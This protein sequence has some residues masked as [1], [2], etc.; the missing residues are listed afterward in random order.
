MNTF[1]RCG[2][3]FTGNEDEPRSG[4]VLVSAAEFPANTYPWARAEQAGRLRVR[5]LT[6]G[7]VTP[8]RVAEAFFKSC[9]ASCAATLRNKSAVPLPR[10]ASSAAFSF[11][12]LSGSVFSSCAANASTSA[13]W[14]R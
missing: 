14:R 2:S 7:Y 13:G 9:D 12:A 10:E 6:S 3:L 5:R 11:S 8:D 4:E 1:V